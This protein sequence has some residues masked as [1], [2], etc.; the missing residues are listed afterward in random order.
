MQVR[1]SSIINPCEL[2]YFPP[3]L[4]QD[5]TN[6]NQ[7]TPASM[8]A[9]VAAAVAAVAA[10]A[11]SASKKQRS[12]GVLAQRFIMLFMEKPGTTI[13]LDEAGERL[14]FG[15]DCPAEEKTKSEKP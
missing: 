13:S 3:P 14:I 10:L 11:S 9:T 15:P 7:A 6:N 2:H 1:C 4:S 5:T 12:M 8:Q